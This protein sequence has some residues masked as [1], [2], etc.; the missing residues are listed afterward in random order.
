MAK[1]KIEWTESTWNPITGCSHRSA[2]CLHCYAER[3]SYRLKAMG[4]PNYQNGFKVTFHEEAVRIPLSWKKAQMIFVNSMSDT[5]HENVTDQQIQQL[6]A[7]MNSAFWHTF[8]VL[9][10][11]AER[12]PEIAPKLTWTKNIWLG[13]SIESFEYLHRVDYLRNTPAQIKF[14]SAEPLLKPLGKIDL[15]GIDW[16]I[17]GG[18]SGPNARPMQ[19]S[20]VLEILEQCKEQKVKFFFKQWGGVIKNK[21]GRLLQGRTWDEKPS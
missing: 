18:E 21:R 9:T 3:L 6:F 15:S 20:W 5:F 2:G 4:Q 10:K 12:L 19:E 11:R 16:V 1:S 17:V 13:V 8:Q 14:I 7:T